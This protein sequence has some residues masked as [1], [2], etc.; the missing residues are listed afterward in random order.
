VAGPFGPTLWAGGYLPLV[1]EVAVG[2]WPGFDLVR[3]NLGLANEGIASDGERFFT[4]RGF[5]GQEL[6]VSR[7]SS[8]FDSPGSRRVRY[9][10]DIVHLGDIAYHDGYLYATA[11]DW[12]IP[13]FL[14]PRSGRSLDIV[15]FDADSLAYSGH[16]ELDA[17]AE[18]HVLDL[19]DG[20]L[21]GVAVVDGHLLVLEYQASGSLRTPRIF[22][23]ELN[24]HQPVEASM[25]FV[26]IPTWEGNGLEVKG[27]KVYVSW[28]EWTGFGMGK[29]D[30]YG[31]TDLLTQE[32]ALPI[33][34][35]WYDAP[36]I[37]AEG[38]TFRADELW[39]AQDDHVRQLLAPPED[40]PPY[41]WR[42]DR[43]ADY[44]WR[45]S[46][47]FGWFYELQYPTVYHAEHG[48]I[49]LAAEDGTAVA[50]Y[51]YAVG[52]W[53]TT[54]ASAYP[55]IYRTTGLS[56]GWYYYLQGGFPGQRWFWRS[57]DGAWLPEAEL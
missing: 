28:G 50:F 57:A 1:Q 17:F 6:A 32:S 30:V 3:V 55:W 22:I 20:D 51:D 48:W 52:A 44:S 39:I 21:A 38:L 49:H 24:G 10:S 33:D 31:L 54:S 47:W 19:W 27:E 16:L 8:G 35:Y 29:L 14:D 18:P 42:H 40:D 5:F 46:S 15:W 43:L 45:A 7:W 56:S 53:M 11:S 2:E 13:P 23:F 26:S 25:R 36:Y 12:V 41:P 37:H 9:S 34:T 4:S